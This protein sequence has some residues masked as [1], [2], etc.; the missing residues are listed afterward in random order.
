VNLYYYTFG[1]NPGLF[2]PFP[3]VAGSANDHAKVNSILFNIPATSDGN[4]QPAVNYVLN[5]AGEIPSTTVPSAVATN[6]YSMVALFSINIPS[7]GQYSMDIGHDDGMFFGIDGGA[8]LISG[9]T[10]PLYHPVTAMNSYPVLG[11]FDSNSNGRPN[12]DSFVVNFPTAGVYNMEIDYYNFESSSTLQ[13]QIQG[14]SP[15]PIANGNSLESGAN[16]PVWPAWTT[17]L[18]PAY[19][20]VTESGT[21]TSPT[22]VY[23]PTGGSLTWNNHGPAADFVWKANESFTT[24]NSFILDSNGSQEGPYRTGYTGITTPVWATALNALTLD[25]PNLIWINQG[26][27]QAPA[28]GSLP[29]VRVGWQYG[30]ALVNT[31]DDTVSNMSPL[32]ATTGPFVGADYVQ[33]PAGYGL[34]PAAQ[35]DPQADWVAIYRTTDGEGIPLLVPGVGNGIYTIP[36]SEY[37]TDGYHDTTPDTGLNNQIQ[38]AQAGENTPP[39]AGAINQVQHLNRVFYSIGNVVYWTS[40]PDTPSGNGLNGTAPLNFSEV[41]SLVKRLVATSI[42]LLVFTVSDVYLIPGQGTT[43][44]PLQAAV[45]YL[46]GVGILSYNAVAECGTIIGIFTTDSTFML[47]S[48]GAGFQD[49]GYSIGNLF[50]AQNSS[51]VGQNFVPSS[52]YVTW[53]VTGEDQA[54]YVSDGLTG[55]YRGCST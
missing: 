40:G 7:A 27:G 10:T 14:F 2:T 30:V 53:H 5:E 12:V 50:R 51:V 15:I 43:N 55:W 28:P 39:A 29:I 45:P 23:S 41:P 26:P 49:A 44:N 25:N 38:G 20:Q 37:L 9:L 17:A 3:A 16:Q 1:G 54:W 21:Y 18:A 36:L 4:V 46:P 24:A 33:L 8:Q 11:G 19:P 31:L 35:I 22:G 52:V 47:I 13:L 32:S 48:P 42:G 6:H 34:P